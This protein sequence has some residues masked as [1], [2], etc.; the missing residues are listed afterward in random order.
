MLKDKSLGKKMGMT[1]QGA[2]ARTHGKKES[3]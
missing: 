2:L 1:E 3:L